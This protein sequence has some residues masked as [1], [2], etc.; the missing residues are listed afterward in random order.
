MAASPLPPHEMLRGCGACCA[1]ST[2]G[3]WPVP[4]PQF[5]LLNDMAAGMSR[6]AAKCT[7]PR[8]MLV[9][10]H[11]RTARS[12]PCGSSTFGEQSQAMRGLNVERGRPFEKCAASRL[13]GRNIQ[14]SEFPDHPI[15]CLVP[16]QV[17][18]LA[19]RIRTPASLLPALMTSLAQ[20]LQVAP[21]TPAAMRW[22][23]SPRPQCVLARPALGG[24]RS[25][26]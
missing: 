2:T 15:V 4:L 11:L 23:R 26:I 25:G 17:L 21:I 3:F 9:Y 16:L 22:S 10:H 13:A 18:V 24:G 8:W 1:C 19:G 7:P 14:V 5:T 12:L 6:T 20:I